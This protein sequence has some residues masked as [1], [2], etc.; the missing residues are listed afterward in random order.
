MTVG[1]FLQIWL[2]E[3]EKPTLNLSDIIPSVVVPDVR[4][5]AG[6]VVP[7][8][9]LTAKTDNLSSVLGTHPIEVELIPTS[10]C[11]GYSWLST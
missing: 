1:D 4:K 11:D 5:Q 2:D 7:F 9:V 8:E 10:Y 3:V 6:K